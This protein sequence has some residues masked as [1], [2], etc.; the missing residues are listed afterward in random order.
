MILILQQEKSFLQQI[1]GKFEGYV[2]ESDGEPVPDDWVITEKIIS[3]TYSDKGIKKEFN[4]KKKASKEPLYEQVANS[5][6]EAIVEKAYYMD[7]P[8]FD[9]NN[10][11]IAK[12]PTENEGKNDGE[13][14]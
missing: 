7:E 10:T 12:S 6:K 9:L 14:R 11:T 3:Q 5:A 1:F 8:Q 2:Y 13:N 4:F